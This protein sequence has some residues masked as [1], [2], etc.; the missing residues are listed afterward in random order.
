MESARWFH[1]VGAAFVLIYSR[2]AAE[3]LAV[4]V[5]EIARRMAAWHDIDLDATG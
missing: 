4:P 2:S 1:V 5:D 3:W